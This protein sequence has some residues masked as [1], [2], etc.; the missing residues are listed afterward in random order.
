MYQ[1]H[2]FFVGPAVQIVVVLIEQLQIFSLA[3]LSGAGYGLT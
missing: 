1:S 3:N 2:L